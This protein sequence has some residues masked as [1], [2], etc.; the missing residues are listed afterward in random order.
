MTFSSRGLAKKWDSWVQSPRI[1]EFKFTLYLLRQSPLIMFGIGIGVT[2]AVVSILAPWIAPYGEQQRIW[3]QITNPPSSTHLLGTDQDGGDVFSRIMWALRLDLVSAL[4][5][6]A[7]GAAIGILVGA[8]SGF[9]GGKTDEVLMRI[10]DI[11][12]AFPGLI[13]A[14]AVAAAL[15]RNWTNLMIALMVVWWPGY[16]RLI[17]GQVLVEKE[18]LYVEAARSVG[19]GRLRIAFRHVLP[20]SIFP[21]LVAVT[22]DIGGVM[23]TA[24]GLSFIGFGAEPGAAELGRM[25][26]DGRPFLFSH[27]WIV[28][29]PGITMLIT[30]VGFNLIGDGLRDVLDPR[31]RR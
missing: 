6:V 29:F 17:R 19:A 9:L 26:S 18:K 23:L 3:T 10:T 15:G 1:R 5:V 31:L 11:F 22:L 8:L 27:P 21:L 16:A 12:L 28:M 24:A 7:V 25:V 30:A 2:A 20:N 13:L 14:M 4:I